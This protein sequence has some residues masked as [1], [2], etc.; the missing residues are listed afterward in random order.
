MERRRYGQPRAPMARGG[1]GAKGWFARELR[2]LQTDAEQKLW[3]RLRGRRTFGFKFRRQ[4]LLVGYVAD[5]Y[6]PSVQLVVELDGASHVGR[7]AYDRERSRIFASFGVAVLRITDAEVAADL[8][9]V[10]A[11]IASACLARCPPG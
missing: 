10:V 9:S 7:E 1:T 2:G 8:A 5:F 6:C 4:H 3:E 11:R